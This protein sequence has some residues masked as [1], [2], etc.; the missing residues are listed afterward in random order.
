MAAASALPSPADLIASLETGRLEIDRAFT[1]TD[2]DRP[3]APGKWT[4]W[5]MLLHIT[6]TEGVFL[7]R[8]QRA[9]AEAKP[10][11]MAI[12]PDRWN[13]RLVGSFRN[14]ATARAHF[15]ATRLTCL[16]L[17]GSLTSEEWDKRAVHSEAGFQSVHQIL[18]KTD[19]HARHHLTQ[20]AAAAEGRVWT[21]GG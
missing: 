6:D 11:L 5:N 9:L 3:Y 10:L 1:W 13:A 16:E 4:G 2:L 20:V 18:H 7:E 19:W 17:A 8:L 21:P 12:D 14:R 15:N